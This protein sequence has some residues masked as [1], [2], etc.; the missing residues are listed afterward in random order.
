MVMPPLNPRAMSL[1]HYALD[2]CHNPGRVLHAFDINELANKGVLALVS[3]HSRFLTTCQQCITTT[4]PRLLLAAGISVCATLARACLYIA[5]YEF[6]QP[7][8][9]RAE[10]VSRTTYQAYQADIF[11]MSP[12]CQPF[13]RNGKQEGSA[14]PRCKS[15][16][17]LLDLIARMK[18]KLFRMHRVRHVVSF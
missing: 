10:A 6:T 7:S 2:S 13:T 9:V 3:D 16:L 11:L 14:D 5:S 12:P 1:Q 18:V 17:F 8:A 15:F 4:S